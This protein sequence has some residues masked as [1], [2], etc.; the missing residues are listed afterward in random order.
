MRL[1]ATLAVLPAFSLAQTSHQAT[2]VK[3]GEVSENSAIVWMRVTKNPERNRQGEVRRGKPEYLREGADVN[4]LEGAAPGMPGRVRL[5][6]GARQDLQGAASTAW[7]AV[8]PERDFTHQFRITGLKPDT[9]YYFSA[10]TSS[11]DGKVIHKPLRGSFRTKPPDSAPTNVTFTVITGL[12]YRDVDDTVHGFKAFESMRRLK[13]HFIVPTGDNVY[14]D[15]EDPIART[16]AVAR[17]HWHRMYSYPN[18]V[19]FYLEVPAYWEK[20]DHDTLIDDCWPGMSAPKMLPLTFEDGKRIFLEQVPMGDRTWR[21]VRWGRDLQIWLPEGRDFR[22]PNNAP[23]GPDK[24][25]WGAEQKRWIK[26]TLLRSDA[27]WKVMVSPTPIVGPDRPK[28][29][30]NHSNK[31]FQHEGDEF[32]AWVRQHVA[33]NFFVACGDRHWQYHSVHPETGMIEFASG[34]VSDEH[35]GGSPGEDKRYHRFHRVKGGFLSVTVKDRIITFR[36]HDVEGKPVY[37][38]SKK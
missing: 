5:R 29:A 14:Y 28:K 12:M 7:V 35:A 3:V 15:N 31:A 34:P 8:S 19:R 38:W 33:G 24:T 17:Y 6:Y 4:A 27:T 25:I 18:L 1:L 20:D 23:D 26:E 36:L 30:D 11:L 10:E 32:R 21:T 16:V 2:G 13:P 9:L 37:E 22:S